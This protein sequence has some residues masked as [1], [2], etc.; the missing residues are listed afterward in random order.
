MTTISLVSSETGATQVIV[1]GQKLNRVLD[2]YVSARS[3]IVAVTRHAENRD[4]HGAFVEIAETFKF[5]E[6]TI[7]CDPL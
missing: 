4:K 2:V 1:D 7:Q 6:L 5:S 3:R